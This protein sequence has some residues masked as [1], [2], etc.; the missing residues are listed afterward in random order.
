[1]AAADDREPQGLEIPSR[2]LVADGVQQTVDDAEH[3][4]ALPAKLVFAHPIALQ[5]AGSAGI[6]HFR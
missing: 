5:R 3:L 2:P 4:L 6:A 1:M